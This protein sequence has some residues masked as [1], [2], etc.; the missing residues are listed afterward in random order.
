LKEDMPRRQDYVAPGQGRV[1]SMESA[2]IACS[3]VI[4]VVKG[5]V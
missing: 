2:G 5:I 3:T 4:L 1:G